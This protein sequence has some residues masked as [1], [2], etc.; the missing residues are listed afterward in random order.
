MSSSAAHFD[1][2]LCPSAD[3][4]SLRL[5]YGLYGCSPQ[6]STAAAVNQVLAEN[7]VLIGPRKDVV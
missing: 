1:V 7:I 5:R 3:E 6:L 2:F 4:R